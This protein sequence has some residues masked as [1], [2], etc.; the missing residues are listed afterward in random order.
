MSYAKTSTSLQLA[1][2]ATSVVGSYYSA[3]LAKNQAKYEADI[4]DSNARLAEIS[5]QSA[6]MQGDQEIARSSLRYGKL[7]GAQRASL[8]ANG[9]DLG[10]GSAAEVQAETDLYNEMDMNTLR[11]NAL[12]QAFGYRTQG[13]NSHNEAI[14]KRSTAG[15]INPGMAAGSSFLTGASQFATNQYMLNKAGAK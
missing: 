13:V 3:K 2:V 11:A 1:G 14:V 10:E 7:K 4:A 8:A 12:R 9:I 5:A 6:L 15:S